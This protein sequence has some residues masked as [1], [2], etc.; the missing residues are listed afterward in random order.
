MRIKQFVDLTGLPRSSVRFYER[1]GLI[2]PEPSGKANGYREYGP[3]QIERAR[4]IR[5]AQ[6][7]GFSLK[8]IRE[9]VEAWERGQLEPESRRQLILDKIAQVDEKLAALNAMRSYLQRVVTW[10]EG[11][12]QGPKPTFADNPAADFPTTC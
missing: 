9:L 5:I 8:E 1:I 6:S 10:M 2:V 7:L 12:E 11:G 4:A 3:S